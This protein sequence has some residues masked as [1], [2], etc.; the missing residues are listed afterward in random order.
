MAKG[1]LFLLFVLNYLLSLLYA[2]WF[3]NLWNPLKERIEFLNTFNFARFHFLRPAII[4]W[5][6]ALACYYLWR[7]G[8]RKLAAFAVIAQLI[9]LLPFN[10]EIHYRF[11]HH[12]PSFKQFFAEELFADIDRF[13]GEPKYSY[14]VA[15]IGLH[16]AIAQYNGFYTLD[17]YNNFY[18]LTYKYEFRKIIRFELEKNP[19]LKTY[20]DE[21][22]SR[23]YIFVDELGKKYD[24]ENSKKVIRN[25]QLDT[26]A[27]Y[28]MGGRYIFSAVPA[29]NAADNHCSFLRVSSP[30]FGME[31]LL[32][33]RSIA[34]R[35]RIRRTGRENH[36]PVLVI[37][38]PLLQ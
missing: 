36:L 6:F 15:S 7:T 19:S 31:H 5:S 11:I 20:F 22:G 12:S 38:V 1:K 9:V 34:C 18:P 28:D 24:F 37:V 17:T 23:C 27:F 13:I 33:R 16:P 10:E 29:E 26:A 2:L 14:R 25:L 35:T 30:G 3:N 4:Y 21:W 8:W 32:I